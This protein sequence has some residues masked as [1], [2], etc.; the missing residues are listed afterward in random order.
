MDGEKVETVEELSPQEVVKRRMLALNDD[1]SPLRTIAQE[2]T[3]EP[4]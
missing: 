3:N 2:E 1:A 4:K